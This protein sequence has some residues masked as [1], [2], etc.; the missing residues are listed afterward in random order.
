MICKWFGSKSLTLRINFST[1][2]NTESM[3]PFLEKFQEIGCWLHT[4]L[5]NFFIKTVI[6]WSFNVLRSTQVPKGYSKHLTSI[7]PYNFCNLNTTCKFSKIIKKQKKEGSHI[8][9]TKS[10]KPLQTWVSVFIRVA[11]TNAQEV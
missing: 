7:S 5:I 10:N 3:Q 9:N 1:K 4:C 2:I 11:P 8:Y 6:L